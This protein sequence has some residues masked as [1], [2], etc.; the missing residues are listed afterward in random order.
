[1]K[2]GKKLWSMLIAYILVISIVSSYFTVVAAD[3]PQLSIE[4]R[5]VNVGDTFTVD[6]NLEDATNVFGGNFTLQYDSEIL[7][8]KDYAFGDIVS[9]H[10]KNCNLNYQSAGNLIRFTFSGATA[11]EEDGT[12]LTLTFAAKGEVGDVA[13]LSFT[14]YKMYG[15]AGVAIAGN[16]TDATVTISAYPKYYMAVESLEVEAGTQ[17]ILY[18]KLM[19]SS[20]VYGGDFILQYDNDLLEALQSGYGTSLQ[21]HTKS[22]SITYYEG[23]QAIGM[24][25]SGTIP[26]AQ[27]GT[28]LA[29]K[30][31]AKAGVSGTATFGFATY[32]TYGS[33]GNSIDM[34]AEGGDLTVTRPAATAID[35]GEDLVGY[36]GFDTFQLNATFFPEGAAEESVT[37][38][39]GDESIAIVSSEGVVNLTGV[40]STRITA[41]SE[42]GLT[43]SIFVTGVE[44]QELILG[45]DMRTPY[46]GESYY[47][48]VPEE[49]GTYK[50]YADSYWGTY[51]E[52]YDSNHELVASQ[53]L[54]LFVDYEIVV[55]LK[56]GE[57]YTLCVGTREEASE[58]FYVYVKQLKGK[59]TSVDIYLDEIN[60]KVGWSSYVEAVISPEDCIVGKI[61]WT[62][63]NESVVIVDQKGSIYFVGPGV[64][65]VTVTLENGLSD[66][67]RVRVSERIEI[68]VGDKIKRTV[69]E[70][71]TR[72]EFQFTPTES[73]T[74]K[75]HST[76]KLDTYAYFYDSDTGTSIN[77][78]EGGEG[79]N[80]ALVYDFVAGTTYSFD[81]KVYDIGDVTFVLE[82]AK[83]ISK[84]EI[85][86]YPKNMTYYEGL[87][88]YYRLDG[89][90]LKITLADGTVGYWTYG[91]DECFQGYQVD[92]RQ[93]NTDVVITCGSKTA[94]FSFELIENPVESIEV[95][96]G[97]IPELIENMDGWFSDDIFIYSY[98]IWDVKIQI[99]YIDGTSA[100]GYVGS[101]VGNYTI[102]YEDN[103]WETPFTLGADNFVIVTYAGKSVSV[104]VTI[105]ENPIERMELVTAP[106]HVYI[107]GDELYEYGIIGDE[108]YEFYPTNLDGF[109]FKIYY[110]DGTEKIYTTD[111]MDQFFGY[112]EGYS[113]DLYFDSTNWVIGENTV[114]FEYM[115]QMIEYTITV[116]ESTV[117][118]IE[119]VSPPLVTEYEMRY[120]PTFW[121]MQIKITYTDNTSKVIELTK[122]NTQYTSGSYEYC[123]VLVDGYKMLI[124]EE[125]DNDTETYV[126]MAKYLGAQCVCPDITI[127]ENR[128]IE[129]IVIS[130]SYLT[131]ENVALDITYVDGTQEQL[132]LDFVFGAVDERCPFYGVAA[133]KNGMTY[134]STEIDVDINGEIV[135]YYVA[136]LNEAIYISVHETPEV[137]ELVVETLPSKVTYVV[138][139]I[140]DLTGLKLKLIYS[141]GSYE[142]VD[143][144][145]T[146][147][148]FN[149]TTAGT[150]VITV[151]YGTYTASFEVVVTEPE[152][153]TDANIIVSSATCNKGKQV[154]V[155]IS[156]ENNPGIISAR[157]NVHY[158]SSVMTLVGIEDKGNLG[159]TMHSN[160]F[161]N[162]YVLSWANDTI[163]ENITFNGDVVTLVFDVAE[164]ALF[165]EYSVSVSYDYDN[166]DI[167]NF[168]QEKVRFNVVD[169]VVSIVDTIIG[170]VNGDGAVNT[171]DR[172][173]LARYLA[174]WEGY[175]ADT[176]DMVAADINCDGAVNTLDRIALAR[177]LANWEGYEELPYTN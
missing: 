149:S 98:N 33:D 46:E 80:F 105:I 167:C 42:N 165:G 18:V 10:T 171:L 43:D 13:K 1:M 50:F 172:I 177:H 138:G 31:L 75:F 12:L 143:E 173:A 99:N 146:V 144:G 122:E 21:N 94:N 2:K 15:N 116:Q 74:Y 158:D 102:T 121:G 91:W 112:I 82:E 66:S 118:N 5:T 128:E 34:T 65:T 90:K 45:L 140:L 52:I 96:S 145:Y 132:Q 76:G 24:S 152:I 63:S 134:Y 70:N 19:N 69:A 156:L 150:K 85:E 117:A 97:E 103:Q 159:A 161:T 147:S 14:A 101:D 54:S 130:G 27:D 77:A 71:D 93:N 155:T 60:G 37:W 151:T 141:D 124:L 104:P 11:L 95:I 7:E 119:V 120:N 164:D 3:A 86:S 61:T 28:I 123:A 84:L 129:S 153:E 108:D 30:F 176:V 36:V 39:S 22:V 72:F 111:D 79:E 17:F 81:V 48:F 32:D 148:G 44:M 154:K 29:I 68:A 125:W 170:D 62:S 115:N 78:N 59:P 9:N 40:G 57:T 58:D 64:A 92:V 67:V 106:Q 163:M 35:I 114:T 25:Y 83:A 136:V 109:S 88:N 166:Y 107:V 56:K 162:P 142:Y 8:V 100:T 175:T 157:L 137:E 135:G 51:A 126:W 113:Y 49:D 47:K 87:N 174:N 41:T 160:Q 23:K 169:G 168:D 20:T 89:L 131:G 139:E 127:I 4:N 6:V 53:E 110:K 26:V 55:V 38:S 73:G 133:T 16:A